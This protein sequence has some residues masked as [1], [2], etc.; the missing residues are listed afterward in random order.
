M[1]IIP[2]VQDY[3]PRDLGNLE[4]EQMTRVWLSYC[5][6]LVRQPNNCVYSLIFLIYR[7]LGNSQM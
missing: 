2:S 1:Q 5:F 3:E 7:R 6:K 4:I